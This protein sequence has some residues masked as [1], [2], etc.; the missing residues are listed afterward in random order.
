MKPRYVIRFSVWGAFDNNKK[1]KKDKKGREKN[2]SATFLLV[3]ITFGLCLLALAGLG[4]TGWF[5]YET[6]TKGGAWNKVIIA[7]VPTLVVAVAA[8]CMLWQIIKQKCRRISFFEKKVERRKGVFD[9]D[10]DSFVFVSVYNVRLQQ[11]CLEALMGY[12]HLHID[13]PGPWDDELKHLT[14]IKHPKKAKRFL[15][16]RITAEGMTNII[17]N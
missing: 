8:G 6:L 5:V 9:H 10:Y 13:C 15:E 17:H 3:C 16:T 4:V 7:A 1:V 2:T 11:N 12:G 14:Y